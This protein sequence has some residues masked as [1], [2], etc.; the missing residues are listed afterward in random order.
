MSTYRATLRPL[1]LAL[2]LVLLAAALVF[3]VPLLGS[4]AFL[5]RLVALALVPVAVVAYVV[6][7]RLRAWVNGEAPAKAREPAHAPAPTQ[8]F[9]AHHA[10]AQVDRVDRVRVGTDDFL[11]LVLGPVDQVTLPRAG[12]EVAQ[13]APLFALHSG[14]RSVAVR[15]PV[16]GTVV[17]TNAAL[18][19]SPHLANR[20]PFA[21][22]WAVTLSPT[23]ALAR[24]Q[25]ALRPAH[26]VGLWLRTE[27]DGVIARIAG[28]E[29][30]TMQDGGE[31]AADLHTL[32]DDPTFA[33]L[34][35]ELFGD[36]DA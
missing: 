7:P 3:A 15:A 2:P 30:A 25:K 14:P 20:D 11:P 24:E 19:D 1:A 12:T 9:H 22:G 4:M 17:H 5:A 29:L 35:A 28:P 8:L 36:T 13:G 6:S 31:L 18:Q 32:I 10:W 16:S 26:S 33:T 23:P 21:K 27:A 34:K